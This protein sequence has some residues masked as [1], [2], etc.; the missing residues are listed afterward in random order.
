EVIL[1]GAFLLGSGRKYIRSDLNITH[2]V[3]V[4][5][6]IVLSSFRREQ[7]LLRVLRVN[8]S[9]SNV[10]EGAEFGI[11]HTRYL[12]SP[13]IEHDVPFAVINAY[14]VAA[15]IELFNDDQLVIIVVV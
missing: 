15:L 13:V 9:D 1:A 5:K 2:M 10:L 3:Y 12:S 11:Q 14:D 4:F 8:L 6:V 7:R